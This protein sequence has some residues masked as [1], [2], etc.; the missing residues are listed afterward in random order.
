MPVTIDV[1]IPDIEMSVTDDTVL[2]SCDRVVPLALGGEYPRYTVTAFSGQL[3][4]EELSFSLNI[5][6]YPTSFRGIL[7]KGAE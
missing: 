3:K 4:G 7:K 2:L 5:G 6:D 1:T